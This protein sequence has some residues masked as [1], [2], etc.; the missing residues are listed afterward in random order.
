MIRERIMIQ[1]QN[2]QNVVCSAWKK[3]AG[4]AKTQRRNILIQNVNMKGESIMKLSTIYI[5]STIVLIVIILGFYWIIS[6]SDL[7][8]WFK[9]ALLK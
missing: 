6:T 5:L 8:E 7:P 3:T 1:S 2:V 4:S 9:F